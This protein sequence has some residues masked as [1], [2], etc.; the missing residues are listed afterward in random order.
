M[1]VSYLPLSR[2]A[3]Q[4][5]DVFL[6]LYGRGTTF[7]ADKLALQVGELL[8]NLQNGDILIFLF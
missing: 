1:A 7:Y 3:A 2:I 6:V 4:I 5:I 8:E